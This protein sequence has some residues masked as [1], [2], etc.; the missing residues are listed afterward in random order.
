MDP[1]LE[2]KRLIRIVMLSAIL[3]LV[4][5]AGFLGVMV[6]ASV[7]N[8][9][10]M[11][12]DNDK[13]HTAADLSRTDYPNVYRAELM[14]AAGAENCSVRNCAGTYCMIDGDDL[15]FDKK[16]LRSAPVY[17][18]GDGILIFSYAEEKGME[19]PLIMH[20][21]EDNLSD[22]VDLEPEKDEHAKTLSIPMAGEG[23]YWVIDRDNWLRAWG[24]KPTDPEAFSTYRNDALCFRVTI[25]NAFPYEESTAEPFTD[26]YGITHQPLLESAES[27]AGDGVRAVTVEQ[28][29]GLETSYEYITLYQSILDESGAET[30][31]ARPESVGPYASM[32][33]F[34][35]RWPSGNGQYVRRMTAIYGLQDAC[36]MI[37]FAF[38]D[39]APYYNDCMESLLS[40]FYMPL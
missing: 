31:A 39:D 10:L 29:S 16:I 6:F 37:R 40:L 20:A 33:L 1:E 35:E 2:K 14:P 23:M 24:V 27:G 26:E 8:S 25:P 11:G 3:P 12:R 5:V 17:V 21:K 4:I 9:G 7:Y 28:I 19:H 32:Y 22:M 18:R 13:P 15:G 38:D 30:V 36:V 34:V